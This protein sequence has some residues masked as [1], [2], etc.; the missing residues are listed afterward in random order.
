MSFCL[1][2]SRSTTISNLI[3]NA[4]CFSSSWITCIICSCTV[5]VPTCV[6]VSLPKL[7]CWY[8]FDDD[9][10][11]DDDDDDDDADRPVDKC[12][13][14]LRSPPINTSTVLGELPGRRYTPD[15]QCQLIYGQQSYYCGV[16]H[17]IVCLLVLVN[18]SLDSLE[19]RANRISASSNNMKLVHWA[20][21]VDCYIWYSEEG[22]RWG[23][24]PSRP[25]FAVPNVT[26]HPSTARV[27][28]TVLL[29]NGLVLCGFNVPIYD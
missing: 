13:V 1:S 28:I 7:S 20:W 15:Q 14:S 4:S 21:W 29:Y 22:T 27:P 26:A 2:V 25:L 8:T 11:H 24:S 9:V 10:I 19:R 17:R 3:V 5:R 12:L 18:Q 6:R 16:R 23:R